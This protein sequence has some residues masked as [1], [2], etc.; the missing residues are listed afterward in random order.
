[1]PD[2]R[3]GGGASL[4]FPAR[5]VAGN[6]PEVQVSAMIQDGERTGQIAG[7]S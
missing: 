2:L 7:G 1:M 5:Q 6:L 3:H 4:S